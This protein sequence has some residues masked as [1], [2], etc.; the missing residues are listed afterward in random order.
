[1]TFDDHRGPELPPESP[2][3][4]TKAAERIFEALSVLDALADSAPNRLEQPAPIGIADLYRHAR[5]PHAA[6][7]PGLLMALDGNV[8]LRADFARLVA[9]NVLCRFPVAAAAS[10]GA[11]A[12]R[13]EAGFRITLRKSRV[14]PSQV[15]VIIDLAERDGAPPTH[16]FVL[17]EE[18]RYCKVSLPSPRDGTI[19]ILL[20]DRSDLVRALGDH[21]SEVFLR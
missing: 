3:G 8:A 10:S 12:R 6:V 20:D 9:K 1:M 16:L 4:S 13:E 19:Q 14:E 5:D 7:T 18:I 15:Y 21:R 11:V 2:P 17:G